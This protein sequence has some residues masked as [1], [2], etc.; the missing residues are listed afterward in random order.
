MN[1]KLV[2]L[3]FAFLLN[4][5]LFAQ[6]FKDKIKSAKDQLTATSSSESEVEISQEYLDQFGEF[7]KF[8]A[9]DKVYQISQ[10]VSGSFYHDKFNGEFVSKEKFMSNVVEEENNVTYSYR[11]MDF[12]PQTYD[13][14]LYFTN[15]SQSEMMLFINGTVYN[16]SGLKEDGTFGKLV[17]IRTVDKSQV[18]ACAKWPE[19]HA[20]KE[21]ANYYKAMKPLQDAA[22]NSAAESRANAE[23]EKRAKFTI[24]NKDV[25]GL[26]LL[27]EDEVQQGESYR[28]TVLAKLKD[29]S[30]ISTA[31]NGY[32]DEYEISVKGLPATYE[33]P[34]SISGKR[35]TV[36]V[37]SI[38]IPDVA[39]VDG[40]KIVV[41]VKAKHKP[42]LTATQTATLDYSK[43]MDLNYNAEMRSDKV[44]VRG[45]NLRIELKQVKHGVSGES[46]I[47]YKV[48]N[49][50][51]TLLKHFRVNASTAV[52]VSVNGQKGWKAISD[53]KPPMNGTNGGDVTVTVDPSV[54][55]YTLNISSVGGRGGEGGYGYRAGYDGE[56]GRI[57]KS[58]QKV[59]W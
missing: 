18:K 11:V 5:G 15:K 3:G 59:N 47:E 30:T 10:R 31:E 24:T 42:S 48:W 35:S 28:L 23:A 51:G 54:K 34:T 45:G 33:D 32:M 9:G 2:L 55:S 44:S 26:S 58:V 46:L 39:T 25:V 12:E 29:G 7:K 21:I 1:R 6:S 27:F 56:N 14:P 50:K 53:S 13:V 52:N 43:T 49:D 22:K 16:V 37:S 17:S 41:T 38:S 19:D 40:D 20:K 8:R 4:Q 57:E 36:G